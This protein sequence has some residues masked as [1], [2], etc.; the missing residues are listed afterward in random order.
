MPYWD[1]TY[2]VARHEYNVSNYFILNSGIGTD[3]DPNNNYC[4][5]GNFASSEYVPSVI[6]E[7]QPACLRREACNPRA[8]ESFVDCNSNGNTASQMVDILTQQEQY[9]TWNGYRNSLEGTPH[10]WAHNVIGGRQGQLTFIRRSTDDPIFFL[11][12]S[13]VDFHWALWQDCRNHELVA[14][15]RITT[16]MYAGDLDENLDMTGLAI[17]DWAYVHGRNITAA[18]MH[19]IQDWNVIYD[20]G[21]FFDNGEVE[22]NIICQGNINENWFQGGRNRERRNLEQEE[23]SLYSVYSKDIFSKLSE[24][25]G[26]IQTNEENSALFSQ[27]SQ[28]DCQYLTIGNNCKRPK[29][30]DDCS[31]MELSWQERNERLFYDINI[32]LNELIDKVSDYQCM[33]QTRKRYYIWAKQTGALWNLCRGEF[34]TFCDREFANDRAEAKCL[35]SRQEKKRRNDDISY[36]SSTII[37]PTITTSIGNN[38]NMII[39]GLFLIFILIIFI[40]C[41]WMINRYS[42]SNKNKNDKYNDIYT[43]L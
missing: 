11:L 10:A 5:G 8:E 15:N 34:D 23:E 20:K 9:G 28:M 36:S 22:N 19:S 24:K 7:G 6:P 31:D 12:H 35:A 38:N 32:T 26:G 40:S 33:V 41:Y 3:G 42:I 37:S 2:D 21:D 25:I 16:S 13:F 29:Y 43:D 39:N 4:V 30:F 14:G 1:W 27:W 17:Y 18:E